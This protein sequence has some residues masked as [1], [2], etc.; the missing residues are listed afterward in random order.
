MV[1]EARHTALEAIPR[2]DCRPLVCDLGGADDL[3]ATLEELLASTSVSPGESSSAAARLFSF[4]GMMPNFES[5]GILPRLTA[6]LRPA[7][8]LL[9]SANLSP[10]P[11]YAAGVQAVLPL[12]DNPMTR[13]WLMTFLLDLGVERGDGE[14]AFRIE[15]DPGAADLLRITAYFQFNRSREI[16]VDSHSVRFSANE[17]IRLFFSCRHTPG[18]MRSLLARYDLEVLG[19]WVTRSGEEGMFLVARRQ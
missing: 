10:G 6:T 8:F 11:D 5:G 2:L 19:E 18:L 3:A 1:L 15:A 12:Y 4:F 17:N 13:D 14:L 16:T 7:D 9:L